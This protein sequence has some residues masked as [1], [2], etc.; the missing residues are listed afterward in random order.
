[1]RVIAGKA[2]GRALKAVPG[3]NTRPTGD[4]VKE[5]IFSMIGPYFDGGRVL[6]LFAGTGALG[7][8]ALSRGAELAVFVDI[9]KKSVHIIHE[10]L[11]ATDLVGQAEV[12]C[13]EAT[14]AIKALGRRGLEFD[15]ILLDPPYHLPIIEPLITLMDQWN[16]VHTSTQIVVE[17]ESGTILPDK[18]GYFHLSRQVDY[19]GTL[20]TIYRLHRDTTLDLGS[21]EQY[22]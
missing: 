8:E 10:N 21:D 4:K 12:Y 15:L 22:E 20:V 7:I 18:I 16:I 6:D 17:Q 13:N 5:A 14:R 19:G 11:R 1:M 2:K 9:D 3:K